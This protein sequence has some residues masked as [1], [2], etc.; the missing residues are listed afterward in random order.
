MKEEVGRDKKPF[1]FEV[2]L[3]A[4]THG[5]SDYYPSACKAR[6]SRPP[7]LHSHGAGRG[8]GDVLQWHKDRNTGLCRKKCRE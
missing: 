3:N 6:E 2:L 8:Q 7:H 5:V 4:A 1:K